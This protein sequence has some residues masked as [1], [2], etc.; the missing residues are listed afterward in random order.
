[1]QKQILRIFCAL[2]IKKRITTVGLV[3]VSVSARFKGLS[4][5]SRWTWGIL[6]LDRLNKIVKAEHSGFEVTVECL[7]N[8]VHGRF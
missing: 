6:Y 7:H 8:Q 3:S 2:D 4:K 1:L 5:A